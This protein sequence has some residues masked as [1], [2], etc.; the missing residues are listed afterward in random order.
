[1]GTKKY[2]V[3]LSELLKGVTITSSKSEQETSRVEQNVVKKIK[4]KFSTMCTDEVKGRKKKVMNT[5]RNLIPLNF[6]PQINPNRMNPSQYHKIIS[7]SSFD[8]RPRKFSHQNNVSHPL[9]NSQVF[10]NFTK[11]KLN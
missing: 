7:S 8:H 9:P 5:K 1:M 3:D 4:Q 11:F 6:V 10:N 2:N